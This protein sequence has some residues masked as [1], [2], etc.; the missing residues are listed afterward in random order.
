MGGLMGGAMAGAGALMGT[1][2]GMA[3][4]GVG[5]WTSVADAA[6][7]SEGGGLTAVAADG[8][9][10][11]VATPEGI[12]PDAANGGPGSNAIGTSESAI[13][14][15][16]VAVDPQTISTAVN[17]TPQTTIEG[18]SSTIQSKTGLLNSAGD[19]MEKNPA[20]AT[21]LGTAMT[22]FATAAL[23]PDQEQM[24]KDAQEATRRSKVTTYAAATNNTAGSFNM[25]YRP[26][27]APYTQAPN[28]AKA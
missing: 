23:S 4:E 9:L 25:S 21:M 18:G 22:G 1:G 8:G 19:W 26:T 11:P 7:A 10:N 13:A 24:A 20:K 14:Q 12:L 28:Y 3:A 17:S 2:G 6:A 16:P 5:G 15:A 27:T